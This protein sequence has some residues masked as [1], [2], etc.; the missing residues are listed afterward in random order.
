MINVP[1]SEVYIIPGRGIPPLWL[2]LRLL[3]ILSLLNTF[4]GAV[5]F[6][7]IEGLRTDTGSYCEDCTSH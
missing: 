4:F 6:T 2:F 7:L 1:P 3:P 5:F